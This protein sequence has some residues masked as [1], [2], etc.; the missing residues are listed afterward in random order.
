MSKKDQPVTPDYIADRVGF[1]I[2][3]QHKVAF[4]VKAAESELKTKKQ[5]L[6]A[7]DELRALMENFGCNLCDPPFGDTAW[8]VIDKIKYDVDEARDYFKK[9]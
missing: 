8:S 2:L 1:E 7:L 3:K 9:A 5:V 6:E 4:L